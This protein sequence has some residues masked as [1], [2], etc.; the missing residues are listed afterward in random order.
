[1]LKPILL[2]VAVWLITLVVTA[3]IVA[4]I[5]AF[6][7]SVNDEEYDSKKDTRPMVI[8]ALLAFA[9]SLLVLDFTL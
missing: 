7:A 8:G 3:N 1:M 9:A 2:A 6:A 5:N 4:V